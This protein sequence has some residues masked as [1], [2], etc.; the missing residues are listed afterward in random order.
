MTTFTCDGR[1]LA[2]Q[3]IIS[4]PV[5]IEA[6]ARPVHRIVAGGAIAAEAAFVP[7]LL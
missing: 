3:G 1:M 6:P 4:L 5:M 7:V 2:S